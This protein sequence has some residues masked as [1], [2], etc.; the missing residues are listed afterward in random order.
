VSY[1][2]YGNIKRTTLDN[3]RGIELEEFSNYGLVLLVGCGKELNDSLSTGVNLKYISERLDRYSAWGIAIDSGLLYEIPSFGIMLGVALQNVGT[4]IRFRNS[5]ENLPF[6]L[7]VGLCF[8][9]HDEKGLMVL[10]FNNQ[11]NDNAFVFNFGAEYL[12]LK[13]L[14]LRAGFNGNNQAGSGLVFGVGMN[15]SGFVL[16]YAISSY[17]D[18]GLT[19]RFSI[20]KKLGKIKLP[21]RIKRAKKA[22]EDIEREGKEVER[23]RKELEIQ[24]KAIEEEKASLAQL[25]KE[26]EEL[27]EKPGITI[28]REEVSISTVTPMGEERE[29]KEERIT[30]TLSEEA[31]HFD[32]GSAEIKEENFP[33]LDRIAAIIRNNPGCRVEIN[34]HTD[35]VGD[36]ERNMEL[37]KKRAESV[38]KYFIEKSGLSEEI[39]TTKGFGET[40]PIASN[41]TPE[42]RA[43]NRRVEII[44]KK[45]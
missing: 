19:H 21:K 38:K 22:I 35:N 5:T 24:M 20:T 16:D 33:I 9:F 3:P 25:K 42:G 14:T 6:S 13:F 34:G 8:K 39:F 28:K 29:I 11:I 2:N 44:L 1:L 43:K 41:A 23:M 15:Y 18:L 17:G 4:N 40:K 10:D 45:Q 37:S 27:I 7:K 12:I 30:I 36:E 31:I 26:I 32:F